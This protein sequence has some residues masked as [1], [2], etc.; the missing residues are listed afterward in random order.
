MSFAAGRSPRT[1]V[2]GSLGAA[3]EPKERGV[4]TGVRHDPGA[5]SR[6]E[7]YVRWHCMRPTERVDGRTL[8][9]SIQFPTRRKRHG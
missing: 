8:E 4:R 6:A 5:E 1:G 7:Q 9:R 3:M 2:R